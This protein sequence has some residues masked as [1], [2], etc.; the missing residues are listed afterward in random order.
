MQ[1]SLSWFRNF[2]MFIVFNKR[3]KSL[4]TPNH[5][6]GHYTFGIFFLYNINFYRLYT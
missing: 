5:R 4:S 1:I 6:D 2:K 3:T